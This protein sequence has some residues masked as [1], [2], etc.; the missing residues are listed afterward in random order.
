MFLIS[1]KQHFRGDWIV[2]PLLND[3][4]NSFDILFNALNVGGPPKS[5]RDL[6]QLTVLTGFLF[7]FILALW[8]NNKYFHARRKD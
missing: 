8:L 2:N 5:S 4:A 7:P 6:I 3:R 1:F